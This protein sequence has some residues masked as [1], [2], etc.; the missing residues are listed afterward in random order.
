M[1][2]IQAVFGKDVN[3]LEE[4][5]QYEVSSDTTGAALPIFSA[6]PSTAIIDAVDTLL[7]LPRHPEGLFETAQ[8]STVVDRLYLLPPMRGFISDHFSAENA[9]HGVD[10]LASKG[11]TVQATAAGRVVFSSWTQDGGYVLVLQHIHGILSI[12]KHNSQLLKKV[13]DRVFLGDPIAIIGN[14]GAL[15]TGPHLHFEIWY[16]GIAVDPE[17][18]INFE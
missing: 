10:L 17:L 5:P 15:S 3:Y 6:N 18:F 16:N 1:H 2:S 8:A 14:T 4:A 12:Y 7:A 13:G 9:H 11:A